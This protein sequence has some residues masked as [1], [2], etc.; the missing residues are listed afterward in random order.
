MNPIS[1]DLIGSIYEAAVFPE[2]WPEVIEN[3]SEEYDLW[4][5]AIAWGTGRDQKWLASPALVELLNDFAAEGWGLRNERLFRANREGQ[6][7]FVQD[8]DLFTQQEWDSLPIYQDFLV[9]RG[10]GYGT[11]TLIA[12][13]AGI[14]I[15]IVFERKLSQ[16]VIRPQT[17]AVLDTLRPH[18]ARSM[19]LATD[20]ERQQADMMLKGLSAIA[21]PAAIVQTNGR[22]LSAN[23]QFIHKQK[24][25]SIHAHDRIF[26][27]DGIANR[28]LYD[29]ISSIGADHV[30]SVPL[31][32]TEEDDA[33]IVHIIPLCKDAHDISLQG[34]AIVVVAQLAR[35]T[36][37]HLSIIRGLY[38]LTRGEARVTI[39]ILKGLALPSVA[40]HL[41]ISYETVRSVAKTVYAKTGS[42]GQS[43][44][45]RRL[46]MLTRYDV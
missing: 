12:N 17:I 20:H 32:A 8:F 36:G 5:G 42:A 45:V 21:A 11:G 3:I 9:P 6:F 37:D 35:S 46:S 28:L 22:V 15:S 29:A 13:A 40:G 43:D 39:E 26:V 4:G 23:H 19:V 31:P 10:F 38:D 27:G 1:S 41:G 33:C 30:K 24:R 16:G 44:L 7:S 25:V 34:S 14:D 18:I 2:R